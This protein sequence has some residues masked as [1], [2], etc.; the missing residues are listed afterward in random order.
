[1]KANWKAIPKDKYGLF[2]DDG[3]MYADLPIIVYEEDKANES[4]YIHYVDEENWQESVADFNRERFRYYLPCPPVPIVSSMTTKTLD[5]INGDFYELQF[6]EDNSAP[7][8]KCGFFGDLK[9]K[10]PEGHKIKRC[11][12]TSGTHKGWNTVEYVRV[13]EEHYCEQR[14][15]ELEP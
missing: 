9:C 11:R 6:F 10:F 7:C 12:L 13:S 3:T 5:F 1:M 14:K 2:E 15:K 4:F 8:S